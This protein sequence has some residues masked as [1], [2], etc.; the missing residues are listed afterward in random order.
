M[1]RAGV[2]PGVVS[3][4]TMLVLLSQPLAQDKNPKVRPPQDSRL[5]AATTRTVEEYA[6]VIGPILT[7]ISADYHFEAIPET[8]LAGRALLGL[9]RAGSIVPPDTLVRDPDI[10]FKTVPGNKLSEK[11][12]R[13]REAIGD[14]PLIQGERGIHASMHAVFRSLDIFSNYSE[15]DP[16]TRATYESGVGIGLF[17]EDKPLGGS[18]FVRNVTID[19]PAHKQGLRPG[20]EL[21]EI[22]KNHQPI[23]PNTPTAQ[24]N[25]T[26][27]IMA[28]QREGLTLTIRNLQGVK[29][30][31]DV[32]TPRQ[33]IDNSEL[34]IIGS[35]F[36]RETMTL[37]YRPTGEGEWDYWV[38]YPRRIALLRLGTI[39]TPPQRIMEIVYQLKENGLKG[40]IL[41]LRDCPSGV[42]EYSADLAGFFLNGD[43]LIAKTNHRNSETDDV[44]RVE[45]R[46]EYRSGKEASHCLD[47]PLAVLIGPDTSG[48]AELIAAALQD[49]KRATI[50]G[51]RSRGKSTIQQNNSRER[52]NAYGIRYSYRLTVGVFMR[53]SGKNLHRM[54]GATSNDDWGV[55][56]DVEVV[57][58]NQMRRQIRAWWFEHDTRPADSLEPTKMDDI[59]NDPVM[60]AAVKILSK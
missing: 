14:M 17:L 40:L 15:V 60:A 57:L 35:E 9:Y 1:V 47:L 7:T 53:P 19:G 23:A 59:R 37:G 49:H 43:V 51:Q 5:R 18:Y 42:P 26:M 16:A 39:Q 10:Y 56:P 33:T 38:D 29:K 46:R 36:D 28:R 20:D 30:T 8:A 50:I 48:A 52:E 21:L 45:P 13:A 58:P 11:L 55:R 4:L 22:G 34:V 31:I 54:P 25:A 32:A 12:E 27:T 24:V 3:L 44:N 6:K 2:L 41:D